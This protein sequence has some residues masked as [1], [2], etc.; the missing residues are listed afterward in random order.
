LFLPKGIIQHIAASHLEFRAYICEEKLQGSDAICGK[1]FRVISELRSHFIF[2][3]HLPQPPSKLISA[4]K[5]DVREVPH[6]GTNCA[7]CLHF[8][9]MYTHCT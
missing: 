2:D 5:L 1:T 4:Y 8:A 3:H 9:S 7:E 6:T